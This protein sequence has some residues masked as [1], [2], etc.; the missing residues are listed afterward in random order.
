MPLVRIPDDLIAEHDPDLGVAGAA[1]H[2]FY[3]RFLGRGGLGP[4]DVALELAHQKEESD[5]RH[6]PQ[7]EDDEQEQAIGHEPDLRRG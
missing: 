3:A 2:R 4:I 5:D 1:G 6:G 7:Y